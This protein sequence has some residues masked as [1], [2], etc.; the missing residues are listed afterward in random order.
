[1]GIDNWTTALKTFRNNHSK[2][3]IID[4]D[5][6]KIEDNIFNKYKGTEIIIGGPPCQGFSMSGKRDVLDERNNLFREMHRVVKIIKPKVFVIENV[7]GLLSMKS[8]RGNLIKD[9]II[10]SFSSLG[11]NI[12]YKIMDAAQHG[13][14][15]SRKRVIF[16][17][18]IFENFVFPKEK[19]KVTTVGEA[20]GNIPNVDKTHYEEPTNDYQ[21]LMSSNLKEIFNHRAMNHNNDIV[22]RISFVPQGGNWKDVPSEFYNVGGNH[23]NNYKRLDPKKPSITLKHATKSMIIHPFHDRVITAREVAR[24]QSFSDDFIFFGKIHEQHQQLANAVPPL[25]GQEIAKQISKYV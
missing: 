19:T 17:G 24:L 1:M 7:V 14:P 20:L 4:S 12:N 18:T 16:V 25:L 3:K 9:E 21:F 23:S 13:V 15:Q 6:K 11:Y 8:T 22:K 10:S 2:P 5:I